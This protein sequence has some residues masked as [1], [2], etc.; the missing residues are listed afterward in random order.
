MAQTD[1]ALAM[2]CGC[3]VS[4]VMRLEKIPEGIRGKV[5]FVSDSNGIPIALPELSR[6]Q[7]ILI[8]LWELCLKVHLTD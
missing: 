4:G 7:A 5:E 1:G 3:H 6:V 8:E 2:V